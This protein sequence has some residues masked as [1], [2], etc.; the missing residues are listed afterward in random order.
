MTHTSPLHLVQLTDL[1][2]FADMEQ[3]LLGLTTMQSFEAVI[4]QLKQ[5]QPQPELLLL[6]GDLSQDGKAESYQHLQ[7][8][9]SSLKI[10]A[11]WLPGNHDNFLTMQR[12]LTH[13]LF[14]PEK[15]FV[16]GGWQFLLLNSGV[17]G[18]VYGQLSSETLDWLDLQLQ[19]VSDRPVLISLHHPP[20]LMHSDWLDSSTLQNSA[21]FFAVI[22]R[23]PQVKL[24]LFGHVHQEFQHQR[25]GVQYLA[26][27]STCIQFEPRSCKFSLDN[28]EPGF[29]VLSLNPDS[30]WTTGIQ[31]VA[32]LHHPNMAATGY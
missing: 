27:P 19:T 13:P 11:Y 16:A 2:L 9:L 17:P 10:P 23:Y 25:R 24:V 15:S 3:Q 14:R 18:Q 12:S 26:S 29:R 20:F 4:A 7:T 32:H 21:E 8:Q 6:T 31:R 30:S 22:D 1:H 5:L 28:T